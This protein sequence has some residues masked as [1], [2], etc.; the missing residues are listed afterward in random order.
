MPIYEYKCNECE[1][2]FE[3][4]TL[5]AQNNEQVTCTECKSDKVDKVLSVGSFRL[6]SAKE[7]PTA[8]PAGCSRG[9]FS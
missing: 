6:N 8:S 2:I 1:N 7:L 3:V 5:S 4:L 9:G